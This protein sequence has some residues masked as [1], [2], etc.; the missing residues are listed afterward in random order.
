MTNSSTAR[1]PFRTDS[2]AISTQGIVNN[3]I[4][5][6]LSR[7]LSTLGSFLVLLTPHDEGEREEESDGLHDHE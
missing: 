4:R 2:R 6:S 7:L 5:E 1:V 3:A